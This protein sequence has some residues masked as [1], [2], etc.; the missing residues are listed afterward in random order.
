MIPTLATQR[1]D[2]A[3]AMNKLSRNYHSVEIPVTKDDPGSLVATQGR[4]QVDDVPPF[5]RM[6]AKTDDV[7]PVPR[8]IRGYLAGKL[9]LDTTAA[10]YVWEWPYYPQ[11]YVPVAGV[12][13]RPAFVAHGQGCA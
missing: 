10:L 8:R 9:V 3:P 2:C 5:P 11:Y 7:A 12:T 1:R 4:A 6:I 13:R